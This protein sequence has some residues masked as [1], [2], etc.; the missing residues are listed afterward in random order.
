MAINLNQTKSLKAGRVERADQSQSMPGR[1][2]WTLL[3]LVIAAVLELLLWRTFSRIGVFIPKQ[4]AFQVVY[5]IGSQLGI[6]ALNFAVLLCLA[7]L[8]FAVLQLRQAGHFGQREVSG[9]LVRNLPLTLAMAGLVLTL[10]LTLI[11]MALVQDALVSLLLRL[12][13]ILTFSALA[14]DFWRSH[15]TWQARLFVSLLLAGYVLQLAAK[16]VHDELGL[17]L[18]FNG[19]ENLYLPL[20]LAGEAA[21]LLNGFGLYLCYGG[22][23]K[24]PAR[25]MARNWPAFLGAVILVSV[26]VGMTFLT[27]AESDIVPI[28]GL[29]ALGYTMQLPLPLYVMALFFLLYTVFFN[30]GHL[31]ENRE[32]RAAAFGLIL[33]FV[34]GYIF[35]ISNQYLFAL[36]GM[37][38]LTRPELV[39]KW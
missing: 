9:K 20:L 26:F 39:E 14:V 19:L 31:Q 8:A 3:A 24:R 18:N 13:L 2:K 1:L 21:V 23:G 17:L 35:N 11:Q 4:G 38:L 32:R 25:S 10:G 33:I 22:G 30:L 12:G 29:Y 27:V 6:I 15:P 36:T 34:G 28:L 5:T 16:V 37:L 7:T